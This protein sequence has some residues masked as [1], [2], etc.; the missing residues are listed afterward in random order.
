MLQEVARVHVTR[1][2]GERKG[3]EDHERETKSEDTEGSD[4]E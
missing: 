1:I 4:E 2:K 3:E